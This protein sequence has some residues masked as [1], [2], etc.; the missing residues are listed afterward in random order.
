MSSED[1]IAKLTKR[2]AIAEP[3]PGSCCIEAPHEH[4]GPWAAI[5]PQPGRDGVI[6]NFEPV[7]GHEPGAM[8]ATS[9][10]SALPAG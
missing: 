1:L 2:P 8:V 10:G 6:Y 3:C 4:Y 5:A 9:K 7:N